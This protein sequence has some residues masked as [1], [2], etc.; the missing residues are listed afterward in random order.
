MREQQLI[1]LL[2]SILLLTGATLLAQSPTGIIAGAVTDASGALIADAR[3]TIINKDTGLT[4]THVTGADGVYSASSLPVGS[5]KVTAEANGFST[6]IR[7]AV[8]EA[9]STTTV[10]FSLPVGD[11]T[12][13]VTVEAASPQIHYDSHQ[14]GGVVTRTQIESLPLNGRSFFELAK[15]EPG[16]Q[17][18]YRGTNNRTFVPV[19][20]GPGGNTGR[21][22]RVTVD[23]GSIMQVGNGGAAMGFS[24]E[25]VQEFQIAT[26]NFDLSTGIT[27]NGSVNIVS[28][29]GTNEFHG[30]GFF[31]FRDHNLAAYPGLA[32]DPFNPDPFF[33]RRQFGAAVGGPIRRDRAFFFANYE[34]S[35]QRSVVATRLLTPEFAPLS[36][37]TPSPFFENQFSLRFDLRLTEN[38]NLFLRHSHDG[39]RQFAPVAT[40][41]PTTYPSSWTRQPGWADQSL[42]GIT[43]TLSSTLVNDLR[44]S[45]FF[46]SS[47][48][49]PPTAA[50]CPGCVGL[51]APNISVAETSLVLGRSLIPTVLGRRYHL[52]DILFWQK[53]GHQ[54]RFGGDLEYLRGGRVD[55]SDEPATIVLFSPR[56]VRDY[57]A[58]PS[59]PPQLRI[60]LPASFLTLP[61][62]LQLP[63][64]SFT[65][66]IG[67]AGV[68]GKNFGHARTGQIVRLYFQ[69]TWH[70]RPHLTFNYGV[71]WTFDEQLNYDLRKPAYLAPILGPAGLAPVRKNWRNFSPVLGLAWS[72]GTDGKTVLR[73][74]GGIY[75]DFTVP[76]S[77]ADAEAYALSPLGTGRR[78]FP[79][80]AIVNPLSDIPGVALNT[81][82]EFRGN[83]TLFTGA[84]LLEIL[85]VTRAE[86][87]RRLDPSNRNLAITNIEADKT[88]LVY[89]EFT[90]NQYGIH[91]NAGVQR[92][93]FPHWVM[94][95]DFA[96]RRF[97]HTAGGPAGFL[98]FNH[99]NSVRGPVLPRCVGAQRDDPKALCSLGPINVFANFGRAVYKALLLRVDRRFSRGFQLLASYAYS[100]NVGLNS[101]AGSGFN[102]D[103]WFESYGP[104][105]GRDTPHLVNVSGFVDLPRRFQLS[106]I[107]GYS[108][109]NPFSVWVGNND[110]N[111]DGTINDLLPGSRVGQFNRGLG[112][113]DLERLVQ[114]FN[115]NLAGRRDAQGRL[116]PQLR[117]PP[118]YAFGDSY[119]TQDLRLSRTFAIRENWRL[120]LLGEVFNLFNIAN[121][122][123]Y[124]GDLTNPGFG[125]PTSRV[126][127][128]FGS[129][130]PRA[131]QLGLKVSF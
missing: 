54:L 25:V 62:I 131:F 113:R 119:F 108:S 69:D 76:F 114:G 44:F 118:H 23:G 16:V 34:R 65:V 48:E 7:E 12:Q 46:V 6:L 41:G 19:M 91:L 58:L 81:P 121:L 63:V 49:L 80:S 103:N 15:L 26:V 92:E 47:A 66:G 89:Q 71:G 95:A 20:G 117:L 86:L 4:R 124:T 24:Q 70:L 59:T 38:Q 53:G 18:A 27:G 129:G 126:D 125:Q 56:R 123:G 3:V 42:M 110:L 93:I 102:L 97:I 78:S 30:G 74:G 10:D 127:Q 9:G 109:A 75:Y 106:F 84:R 60:P 85:P 115:N 88:G 107:V 8:V 45:Y 90:P 100:S 32:R 37:I 72:P 116:I 35:E 82:L 99:F 29:S 101:G 130:G 13:Q 73:A 36:R 94:S 43:S 83:P 122:Q 61:D 11:V 128:A 50:D 67:E 68:P 98:D 22:T 39:V 79:G 64:Q 87:A 5:Y 51:G 28:R 57:N 111:G 2:L 31:L 77:N 40:G 21:G 14:I 112:K 1:K 96:F 120:T 55:I 52:S 104:F 17:P 105:V 33:Q